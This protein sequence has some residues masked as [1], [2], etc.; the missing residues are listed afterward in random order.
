MVEKKNITPL[1]TPA[2][3]GSFSN[4][5]PAFENCYADLMDS[6]FAALGRNITLHL[7][8]EKTIEVSGLQASTPAVHYNPFMGR[9]PRR[10]P[11]VIST[12]R[13]TAVQLVHR[14]ATYI[15]KIKHGPK[16][17]D[18]NGG[19]ELAADEV[20]TTLVIAAEPHVSE[21]LSATIDDQRYGNAESIRPF[22]FQTNRYI[23]VKWKRIN[24]VQKP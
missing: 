18:N 15:A 11:G 20:M 21:A 6:S 9:G 8:P 3:T 1:G 22:G 16:D 2:D 13:T 12:T 10:V 4:I 23:L 14:D 19:V 7:T 5:Q 24:E 17:A